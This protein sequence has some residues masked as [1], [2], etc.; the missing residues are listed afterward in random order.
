MCLQQTNG[1]REVQRTWLTL[2]CLGE[3]PLKTAAQLK[4][5]RRLLEPDL[6]NNLV[7]YFNHCKNIDAY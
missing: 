3:N 7:L 6:E 2:R 5:K 1:K 4:M